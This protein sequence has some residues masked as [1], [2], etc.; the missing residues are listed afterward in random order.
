MTLLDIF[1]AGS[2]TTSH[3]LGFAIL[4]LVLNPQMGRRIQN[5]I[6][7]VAGNDGN[8][9][10]GDRERMPY[11]QAFMFEVFRFSNIA[12]IPLA[13][14]ADVDYEYKGYH[15]PKINC[16]PHVRNLPEMPC[17]PFI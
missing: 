9:C 4:H 6:R 8:L 2:E 12:P 15:I 3:F 7:K 14:R 10:Y 16:S 17:H 5:E 11:T 13:R 1:L